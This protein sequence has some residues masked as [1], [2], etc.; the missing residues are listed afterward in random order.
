[1]ESAQG[2]PGEAGEDQAPQRPAERKDPP[3][4]LASLKPYEEMAR[5]VDVDALADPARRGHDEGPA[6]DGQ[7]GGPVADHLMRDVGDDEGED[8]DGDDGG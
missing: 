4:E 5:G 1:V 3:V 8:G 6:A 7:I 2:E